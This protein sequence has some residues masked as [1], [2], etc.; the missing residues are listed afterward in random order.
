MEYKKVNGWIC[1]MPIGESS[2]ITIA[3]GCLVG[4]V[5]V[6]ELNGGTGVGDLEF[7]LWQGLLV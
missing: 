4:E 7:P 3:G 1:N 5:M 2:I 6:T